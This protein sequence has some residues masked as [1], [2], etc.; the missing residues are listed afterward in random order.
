MS[1]DEAGRQLGITHNA[2]AYYEKE[3]RCVPDQTLEEMSAIYEVP[4]TELVGDQINLS[5]R[6][7][8]TLRRC[9]EIPGNEYMDFI[10]ALYEARVWE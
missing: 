6:T 1:L 5:K 2:V 3:R 9:M 8:Q 7:R 10:A 4:L